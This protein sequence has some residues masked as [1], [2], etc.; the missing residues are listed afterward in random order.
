[1]FRTR[2]AL[3]EF[4]AA[5]AREFAFLATDFGFA[6]ERVRRPAN[7]FG[8]WFVN[9]TTRVVVEGIHWGGSARVAIGSAGPRE[10]FEDFDLLDLIA[11][12]CPDRTPTADASPSGQRHQ[13]EALAVLL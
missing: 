1:M 2:Q 11:I 4:R 6:E 5:G 9:A 7:E 10:R 3:K 8:V 12:R 13:L